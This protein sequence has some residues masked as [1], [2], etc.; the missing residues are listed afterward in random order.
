MTAEKKP[1][2]S[3]A[4]A[5][6]RFAD[7]IRNPE[8]VEPPEGIEE[9]RMAIYRRL[10]FGNLRNLFAKN[11][12]VM[13]RLL[14]DPDWDALIRDF[15]A[16]HQAITPMFTEIGREFVRFI[17][18]QSPAG[19]PPFAFELAHWEYLETVVRLHHADPTSAGAVIDG[20]LLE[21]PP[22]LNPTLQVAQYRWP[23]H[24][25]GPA[26]RPDAPLDAPLILAAFRRTNDRVGFMRLNAVTARLLGLAQESPRRSG[27][28]LLKQIADE[29][30]AADGDAVVRSG[31]AMLERLRD[32]QV[33]LGTRQ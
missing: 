20:D 11:F 27:R 32:E 12:P 17:E 8:A 29:L 10:F 3:L 16:R 22:L 2:R 28:A 9:R 7:H 15:M 31:A 19:L 13:R 6:K 25:I 21:R 5:Q 14:D 18:E 30:Q 4:D 23:V 33:I 26:F 24:E 1:P